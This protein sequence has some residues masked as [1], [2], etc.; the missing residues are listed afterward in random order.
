MSSVR[1]AQSAKSGHR[2]SRQVQQPVID[3][4]SEQDYKIKNQ[5]LENVAALFDCVK[6]LMVDGNPQLSNEFSEQLENHIKQIMVDLGLTIKPNMHP[7]VKA[8][9]NLK[10]RFALYEIIFAK[11]IDHTKQTQPEVSEVLEELHDNHSM[12]FKGMLDVI[13]EIEPKTDKLYSNYRERNKQAFQDTSSALESAEKLY[14]ENQKILADWEEEQRDWD[15]KKTKLT[16]EISNLE[17]ENKRY[18]EMILKHS[19]GKHSFPK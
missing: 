12:I 3:I 9:H 2:G 15:T 8:T 16:Q 6:L 13:F 4:N 19:K 11:L 1:N 18:L 17:K 10:A 7:S 14:N 5:D